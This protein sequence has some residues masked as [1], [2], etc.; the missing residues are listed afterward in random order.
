MVGAWPIGDLKRAVV[1]DGRR[2]GS[3]QMPESRDVGTAMSLMGMA[4]ALLERTGE[5]AA[6]ALLGQAID[7]TR[8]GR[9]D[10]GDDKQGQA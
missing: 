8:A 10:P 9:S 3:V 5:E 7:A 2:E 6:A 1:G 4:R